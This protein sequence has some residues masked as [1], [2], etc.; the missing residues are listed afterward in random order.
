M[1]RGKDAT[2]HRTSEG[3]T[4]DFY[5]PFHPSMFHPP[6]SSVAVNKAMED[7]AIILH[8]SGAITT[9]PWICRPNAT[10]TLNLRIFSKLDD[11]LPWFS[12]SAR[13]SNAMTINALRCREC[14]ASPSAPALSLSFF[15][16]RNMQRP[17]CGGF[18]TVDHRP[19]VG[20]LNGVPASRAKETH[21][22]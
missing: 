16:E 14:G 20:Q 4:S 1:K 13:G 15:R 9:H 11:C 6:R 3:R 19:T 5:D 12:A 22:C 18:H 2:Q 8:K 10:L 21:G 17:P 7:D